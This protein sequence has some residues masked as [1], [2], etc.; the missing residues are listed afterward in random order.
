M[1]YELTEEHRARLPEWS[2]KWIDISLKTGRIS[3]DEEVQVRQHVMDLYRAAS[4][5]PPR[6]VVIAPSPI[7]ASF[8]AGIAAGAWYLRGNVVFSRRLSEAE[9]QTAVRTACRI[10]DDQ[11][12]ADVE[13]TYLAARAAIETGGDPLLAPAAITG[14]GGVPSRE[15][16]RWLLE[17]VDRSWRMRHSG[18]HSNGETAYISFFR[19]VVKLDYDYSSWAPYEALSHYGPRY[20]HPDFC[21]VSDWPEVLLCDDEGRPHSA[22]GPFC[23]WRDGRELWRWHGIE[24]PKEWI[25]HPENLD[26]QVALTE[27]NAER[28]RAAAEIIGWSKI[29]DRLSPRTVDRDPDPQVGELLEV[30]LPDAPGSRFLRVLCGTGR[31]FVLSVPEGCRTAAEANAW[32]YGLE[33]GTFRQ[34]EVRT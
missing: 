30:D 8:A 24:V 25:L 10:A 31:T 14:P 4:L 16:V 7:C 5:E 26:P 11:V 15:V 21:V 1:S 19:H 22:T 33:V 23:R 32:T 20:V 17:C 9:I 27:V 6:N 28:R 34:S 3:E 2:Q 12:S 29:L 13:D 18:N